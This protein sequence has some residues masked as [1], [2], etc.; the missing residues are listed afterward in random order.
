M[1]NFRKID[2]QIYAGGEP[3]EKDL[4]YLKGILGIQTI[5]S[6]D[7]KISDKIDPWCK[8]NKIKH[9]TVALTGSESSYNDKIKYVVN[10]LPNLLISSQ[11]VYI[12][13]LHGSDRTGFA[14]AVYRIKKQN[15]KFQQALADVQKYGYGRGI[16]GTTQKL[17]NNILKVL[18]SSTNKDVQLNDD[19]YA[20]DMIVEDIRNTLDT[21]HLN[22]PV[23]PT[24]MSNGIPETQEMVYD[25]DKIGR[26]KQKIDEL[27]KKMNALPSVGF[28]SGLGPTKG[29]GPSQNSAIMELYNS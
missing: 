14:V 17:F 15:L 3:D 27:Y 8:Q 2:Q 20:N 9:Y 12:H 7:Q 13:C 11:P 18:S 6:L 28:N 4:N 25:A 21:S 1:K 19:S 26:R 5:V 24:R 22:D 29:F 10:Q 23:G 16:S